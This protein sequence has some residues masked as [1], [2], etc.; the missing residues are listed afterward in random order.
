MSAKIINHINQLKSD[1]LCIVY[2]ANCADGSGSAYAAWKKFGDKA[3]YIP[4]DYNQKEDSVDQL[5]RKLEGKD[6][7]FCD[8][9]L[10]KFQFL[11][12]QEIANSVI[13]L[14]HHPSAYDEIG[15]LDCCLF[16][17]KRAGAMI[18]WET[19]HPQIEPPKFIEYIQDGDLWEFN[20][21]ETKWFYSA[22]GEMILSFRDM[23]K[24]T[25]PLFLNDFLTEGKKLREAYEL[26]VQDIIVKAEPVRFMGYDIFMVECERDYASEVG[27][28]LAK[29]S[30]SFSIC[31]SDR[32]DVYKASLRGIDVVNLSHLCT[33]FN[34]GGHPNASAFTAKNKED[35]FQILQDNA[36]TPIPTKDDVE[37]IIQKRFEDNL[38]KP[39][40]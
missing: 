29:K 37:R 24:L 6:V 19:L 30:G 26:K 25:N 40:I 31:Y 39:K 21:K 3:A 2:H 12:V 5:I 10:K 18:T 27:N 16:D 28:F 4:H 36:E 9:T 22:L 23:D 20:Y 8:V 35:F 33:L 7:I 14:D 17:M 13:V 11:K 32:K 38:K 34:G 15:N 1:N